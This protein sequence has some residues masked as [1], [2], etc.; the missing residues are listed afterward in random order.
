[1]LYGAWLLFFRSKT[2]L[3]LKGTYNSWEIIS[4]TD[5]VLI[6]SASVQI[7]RLYGMAL[8]MAF[9]I[10]MYFLAKFYLI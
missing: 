10:W 9:P 5:M 7:Q 4:Y 3:Y 1:M 8:H 6:I 2:E